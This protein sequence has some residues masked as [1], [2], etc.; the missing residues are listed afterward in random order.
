[1]HYKGIHD[2]RCNAYYRFINKCII[3]VE[4]LF[5]MC[6]NALYFLKA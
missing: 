1:M 3:I 6:F 4:G 5:V 2:G